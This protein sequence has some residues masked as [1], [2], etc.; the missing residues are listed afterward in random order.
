MGKPLSDGSCLGFLSLFIEGIAGS[1]VMAGRSIP[2][3]NTQLMDKT[4]ARNALG[5]SETA[6]LS[7]S[8]ERFV[9]AT[10]GRSGVIWASPYRSQINPVVLEKL[11]NASAYLSKGRTQARLGLTGL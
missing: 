4:P 2:R 5:R 1:A 9:V 10:L 7:N 6:I 3:D 11:R 8:V